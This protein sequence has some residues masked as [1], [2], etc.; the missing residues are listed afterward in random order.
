M[1]KNYIVKNN[2]HT[3]SA[4]QCFHTLTR[5][6][7][8]TPHETTKIRI[9]YKPLIVW[10]QDQN[11]IS[12]LCKSSEEQE[13]HEEIRLEASG[14]SIGPQLQISTNMVNF[15]TWPQ[16]QSNKKALEIRNLS[17]FPV[18]FKFDV[19][20]APMP[21]FEI[22]PHVGIVDGNRHVIVNITFRATTFGVYSQ[23]FFC[24]IHNHVNAPSL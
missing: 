19:D 3:L 4:Y 12:I 14:N 15:N 16:M 17:A 22:V 23:R 2:P 8:L 24:M 5:S 21:I 1:L 9:T 6:F 13:L 7:D 10:S 18:E 11:F 20:D